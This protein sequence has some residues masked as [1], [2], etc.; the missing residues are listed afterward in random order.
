MSSAAVFQ[1]TADVLIGATGMSCVLRHCTSNWEALGLVAQQL[2][3]L[4]LLWTQLNGVIPLCSLQ[5][6]MVLALEDA[7]SRT[8]MCAPQRQ[9]Y[10]EDV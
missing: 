9:F 2:T 10:F 8:D 5:S 4:I 7:A 1:S 6:K 3:T